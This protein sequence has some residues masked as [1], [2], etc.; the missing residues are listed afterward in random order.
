MLLLIALY[1]IYAVNQIFKGRFYRPF[2]S[3][4]YLLVGE[5][6]VILRVVAKD[7]YYYHF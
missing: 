7:L 6:A 5:E 2:F 1:R 4:S 3:R